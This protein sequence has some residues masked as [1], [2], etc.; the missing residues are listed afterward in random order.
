MPV[1]RQRPTSETAPTIDPRWVGLGFAVFALALLAYA[2]ARQPDPGLLVVLAGLAI[3]APGAGM[4]SGA[5]RPAL[6]RLALGLLGAGASLALIAVALDGGLLAAI[7]PALLLPVFA[8]ILLIPGPAGLGTAAA[9]WA[10]YALLILLVPPADWLDAAA[11]W[12]LQTAVAGLLSLLLERTVSA[13][14]ALAARATE[15]ERAMRSILEVSNRLRIS[16]SVQRILEEVAAAVQAAGDFD[17]V[18]LSLVDW[19]RGV[20]RVGVA[21]GA[22]GRRLGAVE[23]LA[24]PYADMAALVEAGRPSGAHAVEVDALPFRS[25]AGELHLVLPLASGLDEVRGLLTVSAARAARSVLVEALPLLEL[26]ANQAA[27][28]LDNAELYTTLEQRVQQATADLERSA[29]EL[30]G[31]R[32]RAEVLYHIARAL[33][34]TLDERQV[35]EQTLSLIAQ[36]MGAD[37]GGIMLVEPNSG[38]L[39]YR[40][41]LERSKAGQSTGLE[42]GQGLAGW[43]LANREPAIV[44]DTRRDAR[45]QVRSSYDEQGRAALAVPIM[46]EQ[47]A[48]GVLI[49]I[50]PEVGH[51]T[52]GDAQIATAAAGQAAA[53]LSKAQLYRYVSEQ[54]EHLGVVARQREEEA[55]RLMS[56]LRS[57]GDGVVV[58]DRLGRVRIVNPAAEQILGITA[59]AFLGRPMRELPGVPDDIAAA[60]ADSLMQKF[61]VGERTVRAHCAAV[62]SSKGES[63]GGVVVYHDLTREEIADR[64]KSE[65]VATASHELRTPMTSI[66]GFVDML[67]I[68]TFGEVSEGQREPLRIIK[69]NVVRLVQ[70]ID[71]LLDMSRMEAGEVRLRREELDVAALLRDVTAMLD[72]QFRERAIALHLDLQDGLPRVLAD[73]Q[74]IEQVALNLI[75]NACKYTPRGGQVWVSLRNGGDE[76]RVDVRD[77]GV[78]IAEEAQQHIFT[79]F[80]RADN[81]LRDEVGGTGLGLSITR[82]L[83]E[84]HGG[85]IWFESAT[86]RGSTFSFTLPLMLPQV[87]R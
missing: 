54:S 31:A 69:N 18:A 50:H 5:R 33:S 39:V 4:L 41:T 17:C 65:L 84:L 80:Y 57:L 72:G 28:A 2:M 30:R 67:L 44:P 53:A 71:E 22:S 25:L 15:R 8:A 49:L 77:T 32:D 60:D 43:V 51:F 62:H 70:L 66:R 81:P 68:G 76:L 55:S 21:I 12:L 64:L 63:L 75:G 3:A 56:T 83:V 86:E 40:T 20:A 19:S 24:F 78:G 46:L 13:Q 36:H 74:R 6:R 34:V 48:L 35:L 1:Q 47:E 45:W 52:P 23:G 58:G 82:R 79:P 73:R 38:R 7:W 14:R 10:G 16:T 9:I 87:G 85:R 42:R 26:L 11:A 29:G 37:R 59:E 27:A 61:S